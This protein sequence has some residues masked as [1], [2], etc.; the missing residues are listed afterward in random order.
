MSDGSVGSLTKARRDPNLVDPVIH[1]QTL[2]S[3]V[4]SG[5]LAWESRDMK[6]FWRV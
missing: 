6:F 4:L 5:K 2:H 1:Q 3:K